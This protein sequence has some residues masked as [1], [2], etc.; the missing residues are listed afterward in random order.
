MLYTWENTT[1]EVE[2]AKP[3]IAL[4]PLATMEQQGDHL[5][6]GT[7]TL[8]LDA[9]S[10]RVGETLPGSV[11]LLPTMPLGTSGLHMSA[12]GTIALGWET[13][14]GVLRDLVGSLLAQGIRQVAVLVG[15]GNVSSGTAWPVDNFIAKTAVRQLNYDY[16]ELQVI[17]AQP[18]GVAGKELR[19]I[20]QTAD[21]EVHAGEVVTSVMLHLFPELVKGRGEDHVPAV[22][23]AYLN[24]ASF[25]ALCP[26]GVWGHPSLASAEK[27]ARAVEVTVRCTTEYIARTFGQLASMR[28]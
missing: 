18:F 11:Y 26:G 8:V 24:Y 19:S 2:A 9:I 3:E 25:S 28:G 7:T 15:L 17:W 21:E 16:P 20:F 10:R 1:R 5:P 14:A 13:L 23:E 22:G 4:L 12:P 27:G 6:V